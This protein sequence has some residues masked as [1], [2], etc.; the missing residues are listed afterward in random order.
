MNQELAA[1]VQRLESVAIRL[2]GVQGN[3]DQKVIVSELIGLVKAS[4]SNN[5]SAAVMAKSVDKLEGLATKKEAGGNDGES[6]AS[7]QA[8]DAI[9]AGPFQTYLTLSK[10][11]GDDVAKHS[12]MVE[13]AFKAQRDYLV[14]AAKSQKPADA[15][16]PELL[17]P[18]S[19][20]ICEIQ[21]FREK[22]RRSNHFNHLSA[23]SESIPALGWVTVSPAPSPFIKEMI[24]AGQFYTNRVL[25]D[26][27]DKSKSH[28]EWVKAW[29][30]TLQEMMAFVKDQHTTGLVWNAKGGDAK[31]AMASLSGT[32]NGVAA[33]PP[34][35]P[36]GGPPPPP[37]PPPPPADLFADLVANPEDQARNQL[38]ADLNKG[39]DITK[40]LKKV[41]SDMQTHKNPE[42]RGQGAPVPKS[43]SPPKTAAAKPVAAA[44]PPKFELDG[45]KWAVEYMVK[46]GGG[47][48]PLTI[49]ET[50][51]N[52]SVYIYKCEGTTVVVKGKVNNVIMDSCKKCAVVFDNVVSSCEF[53]NCQSAQM[54]TMGAV[55][56]I[57]VEKTDGCQMYLS[58]EAAAS[59]AIITA[60]SS[61]MNVLVPDPKDEGDFLEMPIPEQFKTVIQGTKLVTSCTESV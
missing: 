55:P 5:A 3:A 22:G 57:S 18:T 1:L 41:T 49:S 51:T 60:K 23:I 56:T 43:K 17:K 52:Q 40:G 19:D 45:K 13:A 26:W 29:L 8:F 54:Q 25:K 61:E 7:V 24:D 31:A 30:T 53:I 39:S 28:V 36:A 47:G 33:A 2:E 34:P 32:S 50:E 38:F 21:D 9:I 12:A 37:P 59:T 27:K 48:E 6:S 42:L 46:K 14:V 10:K 16:L 58:K 11:I 44:K 15:V 35:P 20:K 4:T